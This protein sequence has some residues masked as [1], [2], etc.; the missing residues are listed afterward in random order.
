MAGESP[1][2]LT[3]GGAVPDEDPVAASDVPGIVEREVPETPEALLSPA[4]VSM[5][6]WS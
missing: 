4:D 6:P 1:R 5:I 3:A 2:T